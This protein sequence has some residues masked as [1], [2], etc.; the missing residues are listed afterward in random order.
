[1]ITGVDCSD[2]IV[3]TGM[4]PCNYY[5]LDW[6]LRHGR[7]VFIKGTNQKVFVPWK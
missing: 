4:E 2:R 5:N 3:G 6:E 7:Y 1:M